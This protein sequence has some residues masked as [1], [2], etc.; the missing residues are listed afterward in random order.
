MRADHG[1]QFTSWAF[2]SRVHD[3]GL[4]ASMC[5][6]GDALDNAVMESFWAQLRVEFLNGQC[7]RTR[8]ES[9]TAPLA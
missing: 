8:V 2:V 9:A 6:V 3:P 7:W 5:T 4:L 1:G